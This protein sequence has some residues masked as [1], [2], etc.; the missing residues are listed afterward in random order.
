M[1]YRGLSPRVRGNHTRLCDE[2]S[3]ERSIPACAGEP[4]R[5]PSKTPPAWV[6]PR[7]CGGTYED[8]ITHG[9]VDGLSPRV[10][11]NLPYTGGGGAVGRSI[12]ACAGEPCTVRRLRDTKPVY[13]RVCGGT[14]HP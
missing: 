9:M 14:S 13:P 10:R 5:L 4:L 11:G 3:I 7:V 1:W 8:S 6:Y 12:P 2:R